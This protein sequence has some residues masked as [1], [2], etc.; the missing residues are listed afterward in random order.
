[1]SGIG[2]TSEAVPFMK[3]E[4]RGR[5]RAASLKKRLSGFGRRK[6]ESFG[7]PGFVVACGDGARGF[8]K[9]RDAKI[10]GNRGISAAVPFIT[11]E[12]IR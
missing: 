2:G 8:E 12:M 7:V 10:S 11:P 9:N 4:I 6:T 5:T 1:M 3:R